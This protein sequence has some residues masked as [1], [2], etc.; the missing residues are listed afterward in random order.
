MLETTKHKVCANINDIP[1]FSKE[2]IKN[3][4]RKRASHSSAENQV[5]LVQ[6]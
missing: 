4:W 1:K 2:T 5:R 3:E 6:I